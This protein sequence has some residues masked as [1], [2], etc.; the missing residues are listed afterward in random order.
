MCGDGRTARAAADAG[1]RF[2]ASR[3]MQ[4]H[5]SSGR[6]GVLL[7]QLFPWRTGTPLASIDRDREH[8][9]A[10]HHVRE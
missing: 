4:V 10:L 1:N 3:V 9:A 8:I 5:P 7:T 2:A 6:D